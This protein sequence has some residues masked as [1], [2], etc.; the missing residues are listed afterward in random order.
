M[1]LT[2]R[3]GCTVHTFL[4]SSKS[5]HTKCDE[6]AWWF[7]KLKLWL[8]YSLDAVAPKVLLP[9][10]LTLHPTSVMQK[11]DYITVAY[12]Y[13][14]DDMGKENVVLMMDRYP[15]WRGSRTGGSWDYLLGLAG[16]Y[17]LW[18]ASQYRAASNYLARDQ[19]KGSLERERQRWS[20][21]KHK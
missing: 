17:W 1:S 19:C 12:I 10:A 5:Q 20:N 7:E 3:P 2:I 11:E 13:N 21:P 8:S 16:Q 6:Q 18:Q 4:L 14:M 15:S 9:F